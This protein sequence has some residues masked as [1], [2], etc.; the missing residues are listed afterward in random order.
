GDGPVE[1]SLETA[2]SGEY[3]PLSRPLFTYPSM[4]SLGKEHVAEF[5]RYFVSQTDN[6][7]IVAG[8]VGYVPATQETKEAQTQKLEDAIEEAQ[9]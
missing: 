3:A 4:E 5:A 8:D 6:E 2:A 7:E 1:P 9:G